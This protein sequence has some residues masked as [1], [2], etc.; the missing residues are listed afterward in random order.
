MLLYLDSVSPCC[1]ENHRQSGEKIVVWVPRVIKIEDWMEL[2]DTLTFARYP[3]VYNPLGWVK[4]NIISCGL[5][6]DR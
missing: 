3:L 1:R 2:L 5:D 6:L 4:L